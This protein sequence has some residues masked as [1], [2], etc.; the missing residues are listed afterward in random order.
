[1]NRTWVKYHLRCFSIVMEVRSGCSLL[2]LDNVSEVAI[3]QE[4]NR[5]FPAVAA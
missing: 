2:N 3:W 4:N 5:Y 1:M